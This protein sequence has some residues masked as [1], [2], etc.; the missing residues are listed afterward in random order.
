MSTRSPEPPTP[1]GAQGDRLATEREMRNAALRILARD[2][3]LAGLNLRQVADEAGVNRGLVYHYFGSR[4]EL[5]RAALLADSEQ[6]LAEHQAG[7]ERT[8]RGRQ[9]AFFRTML[10]QRDALALT[11]LLALDGD[12]EVKIVRDPDRPRR[13]FERDVELGALPADVDLR[14]LHVASVSVV[15]GYLLFREQFSRDL[16]IPADELDERV[17]KTV[18][19]LFR[20]LSDDTE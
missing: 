8:F 14:A 3:V 5:L 10:S 15:Y 9:E 17:V 11:A 18:D 1:P 4:R 7:M 13:V 20:G 6:R 12:P 19:R 16:G 2:G